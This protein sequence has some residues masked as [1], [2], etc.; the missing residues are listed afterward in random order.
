MS[1]SMWQRVLEIKEISKDVV[2][3]DENVKNEEPEIAYN[4]Q[5]Y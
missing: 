4:E 1:S 3:Q 5:K 2:L